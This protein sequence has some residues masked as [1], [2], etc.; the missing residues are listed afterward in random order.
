MLQNRRHLIKEASVVG[1]MVAFFLSPL[2]VMGQL[3]AGP[4]ANTPG[5]ATASENARQMRTWKSQSGTYSIEAVLVKVDQDRAHLRKTDGEVIAVTIDRLCDAD[6]EY[7]KTE[8]NR[9]AKEQTP[10]PAEGQEGGEEDV[11]LEL[12]DTT[13]YVQVTNPDGS[14]LIIPLGDV[15]TMDSVDEQAF[16]AALQQSVNALRKNHAEMGVEGEVADA[17]NPDRFDTEKQEKFVQDLMALGAIGLKFRHEPSED[18]AQKMDASFEELREKKTIMTTGIAVLRQVYR[19]QAAPMNPGEEAWNE[20]M[21][22]LKKWRDWCP[23]SPT[24]VVLMGL[25]EINKAWEIRGT[26]FANSLTQEMADGFLRHL[27]KAEED[28]KAAAKLTDEDPEIYR[29]LIDVAKG[30]GSTRDV[31]YGYLAKGIECDPKYYHL[32][33][34]MAQYLLPRWQGVPGELPDFALMVSKNLGGEPGLIAYSL[35]AQTNCSYDP[36][37]FT[38]YHLDR[39]AEAAPVLVRRFPHSHDILG[40]ACRCAYFG[41]DHDTARELLKTLGPDAPSALFGA[42]HENVALSLKPEWPRH[43][44]KHLVWHDSYSG[45][46]T[47][48][49]NDSGT[50]MVSTGRGRGCPVKLWNAITRHTEGMDSI[51][52]GPTFDARFSSRDTYLAIARITGKVDLLGGEQSHVLRFSKLFPK[53]VAFTPDE[54]TVVAWFGENLHAWNTSTGKELWSADVE[55]PEGTGCVSPD[56]KWLVGRARKGAVLVDVRTGKTEHKLPKFDQLVGFAG[57]DSVVGVQG[58]AIAVWARGNE[59]VDTRIRGFLGK[60]IGYSGEH[61]LVVSALGPS[62]EAAKR[63]HPSAHAVNLWSLAAGGRVAE[64]LGHSGLIGSA[65]ITPDRRFLITG[66]IDGTIRYWEIPGGDQILA[67]PEVNDPSPDGMPERVTETH[68][69]EAGP[70]YDTNLE[71]AIREKLGQPTGDLT[72]DVLEKLTELHVSRKEI[73][74]LRGLEAC[75]NL[76]VLHLSQNNVSDLSPLQ[77]LATLRHLDCTSNQIDDLQPIAGLVDLEYL[78]LQENDIGDITPLR[79]LRKLRVLYLCANP[80]EDISVIG[81]LHDLQRLFLMRCQVSSITPLEGLLNLEGLA[82]GM[83][84]I[85]DVAPLARLTKLKV[86]NLIGTQLDSLE[87]LS[88][89]VRL[90]SLNIGHNSICDLTPIAGMKELGS[91][92]CTHNE[93]TDLSPLIEGTGLGKDDWLYVKNNPLSP[94][95]L[96]EQIPALKARGV[97]VDQE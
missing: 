34:A 97:N 16:R 25:A 44:E 52:S 63:G 82:L 6:K 8:V 22:G 26:G 37:E 59:E 69:N 15:R 92:L 5:L 93:I 23:D 54:K 72:P 14:Q 95:C 67:N 53:A 39:L 21:D 66:S 13:S 90:T 78:V 94:E 43:Q 47:I 80:I 11:R 56:G 36:L 46:T 86:L 71:A 12:S 7:L 84:P 58:D 42:I 87:V 27:R 79:N 45:V 55:P 77:S 20:H 2:G 35:V 51:H 1:M 17:L 48:A 3:P 61:G 70:I 75:K 50:R 81:A 74:S 57:N 32:Y 9:Q 88:G 49:L 64:F 41:G 38:N 18:L 83:N 40:F 33:L 4:T 10:T 68:P 30:L 85:E 28:L 76:E 31:A 19:G 60:V 62:D 65:A 91:L 89:L 24:P 73:T 29:A 96:N